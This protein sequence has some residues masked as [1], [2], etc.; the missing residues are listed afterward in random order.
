MHFAAQGGHVK[1][2]E[3]LIDQYGVD[4]TSRTEVTVN[5]YVI[6]FEKRDAFHAHNSKTDFSPSN[7]NY[8]H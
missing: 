1:I 5:A 6:V 7:D 4:P 3:M 8:I 2:T